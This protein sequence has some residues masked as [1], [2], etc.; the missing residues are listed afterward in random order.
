[1]YKKL[2]IILLTPVM[3]SACVV[4][5]TVYDDAYYP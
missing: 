2:L 4:G 5:T 3:L 1:M